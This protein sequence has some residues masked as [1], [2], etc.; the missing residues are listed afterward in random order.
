MC[1]PG[2]G[3]IPHLTGYLPLQYNIERMIGKP[4]WLTAVGLFALSGCHSSLDEAITYLGE[5][6]VV[7]HRP[8]S[9][10][11]APSFS[12]Q[13]DR[14][15][16]SRTVGTVP[17]S[18]SAQ[19]EVWEALQKVRCLNADPNPDAKCF[20]YYQAT[21]NSAPCDSAMPELVRLY[22][23][24]QRNDVEFILLL[25]GCS[26]N[27]ARHYL[28]RFR[29]KFPAILL[30]DARKLPGFKESHSVPY[31]FFVNPKGKVVAKGDGS[32]IR[33]WRYNSLKA[34]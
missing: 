18:P 20:V 24:L 33:N 22:P 27:E 32:I 34:G 6:G 13:S 25:D 11:A 8:A 5:H 29:A 31:A 26:V 9:R 15:D 12:P 4:V 10:A 19:N 1:I 3:R 28:K 21:I 14:D 2:T 23:T 7:V 30:K 17:P 16:V